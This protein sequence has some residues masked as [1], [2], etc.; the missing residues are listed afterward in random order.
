M[1]DSQNPKPDSGPQGA[2]PDKV[3]MLNIPATSEFVE[4]E[5]DTI[6]SLHKL[7]FILERMRLSEY[8]AMMQQ[9]RRMIFLNFIAGL[10]RGFGFVLGM[11]VLMGLAL[12]VLRE[13]VDLP[14]IG[15]YIARIVD[16]VR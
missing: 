7:A 1:A 12:F 4:L 2:E 11:T 6:R 5:K 8:I 13:L 16:I 14:L 3:Q 9:P 15:K 10:S